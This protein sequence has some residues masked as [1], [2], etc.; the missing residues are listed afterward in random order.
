MKKIIFLFS[1]LFLF[2]ACTNDI[3][4]DTSS[5]ISP[6]DKPINTERGY[7]LG[8]LPTPHSGQSLEKAHKEV[9]SFTELVP[10]WGKPSPFWEKADDFSGKWGKDSIEKNIRKNGMIPLIHFSFMGAGMTIDS[11]K[12]I[13]NPSLS[14]S[15]WRKEY[16]ESVLETVQVTKP[17]Y[18]SLGNEVNRWYEKYGNDGVD[19]NSFG[20]FV[21]LYNEIYHEVKKISPETKVFC[22]FAREMVSELREADLEVL[23]LFDP[24]KL[25]I[26]AFTTYPQS[27]KKDK[28]G[29]MLASPINKPADIPSDYYSKVYN[30][31]EKSDKTKPL[32]FTEISW[33]AHEAMGGENAQVEFINDLSSR[34]LKNQDVNIHFLMW[35]WLT[36][37]DEN[38]TVGLRKKNGTE[39]PGLNT[40]KEL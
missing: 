14:N 2:T 9:A 30:Y 7:Y 20:N 3:S 33:P 18:L 13:K 15:D 31:I 25:D 32:A 6:A 17:L 21:T 4:V 34:L 37:L 35:P 38:D 22:V 12:S 24:D 23:K 11:P 36:D 16:K 26:F 28:N 19:P 5:P 27:V 1:I 29:K 10:V 39:K 8:L 40:W